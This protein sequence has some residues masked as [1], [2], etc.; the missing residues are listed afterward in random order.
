MFIL[1]GERDH[2]VRRSAALE[3]MRLQVGGMG[4]AG[5]GDKFGKGVQRV[6]MEA[7]HTL[8]LVGDDDGALA[9]GV[10]RRDP[11]GAF[12]GVAALRLDAADR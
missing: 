5:R 9:Q 4:K 7:C 10:L 11:G 1:F 12:A 3:M 8:G 2:L 6:S